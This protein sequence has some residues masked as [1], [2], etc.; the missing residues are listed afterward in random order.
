MGAPIGNKNAAG[1]HS[2]ASK[3]MKKN[4]KKNL[5]KAYAR[6]AKKNS[7]IS[8]SRKRNKNIYSMKTGKIVGKKK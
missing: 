7:R 4:M 3:N 8:N 2:K 6:A 5:A 1:S